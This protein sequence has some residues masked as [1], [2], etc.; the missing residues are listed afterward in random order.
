MT[1][2]I[3]GQIRLRPCF[4]LVRVSTELWQTRGSAVGSIPTLL[5]RNSDKRQGSTWNEGIS[6]NA[7]LDSF[8]VADITGQSL[9]VFRVS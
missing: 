1:E 3:V 8:R 9:P 4:R 6:Q 2:K 7:V 5:V